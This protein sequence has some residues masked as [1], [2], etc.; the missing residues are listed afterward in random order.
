[1]IKYSIVG[2]A[3]LSAAGA[4][5]AQPSKA[6]KLECGV[7]YMA[8]MVLMTQ[9][10]DQPDVPE[11]DKKSLIAAAQILA[12]RSMSVLNVQDSKQVPPTVMSAVKTRIEFVQQNPDTNV[13]T[14]IDLR[15]QCDEELA[16]TPK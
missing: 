13:T 5:A 16:F 3:L 12:E 11:A 14:V 1:M 15:K 8:L 9:I 10:S 4:Q 6:R 7:N 2:A